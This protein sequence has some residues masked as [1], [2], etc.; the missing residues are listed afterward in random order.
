M[1]FAIGGLSLTLSHA[2]KRINPLKPKD[3]RVRDSVKS[4]ASE[5]MSQG[6][7][8][9]FE[10]DRCTFPE[11]V[12][13][14]DCTSQAASDYLLT[15]APAFSDT[16][17]NRGHAPNIQQ[18]H[19]EQRSK[20]DIL[21]FTME[22][23][24]LRQYQINQLRDAL[25]LKDGEI[26]KNSKII[27]GMLSSISKV[28]GVEFSNIAATSKSKQEG[29]CSNY[30]SSESSTSPDSILTPKLLVK[31]NSPEMW[32]IK[33]ELIMDKIEELKLKVGE[34]EQHQS[35]A[36]EMAK[37]DEH[38]SAH[39]EKN[40]SFSDF[41]QSFRVE[42]FQFFSEMK[43]K[44]SHLDEFCTFVSRWQ[45]DI[46]EM[47]KRQVSHYQ[48][49]IDSLVAE[50]ERAQEAHI[51]DIAN[52]DKNHSRRI[53]DL[54]GY[55][56]VQLA[57]KESEI[58]LV[59][60]DFEK[61]IEHLHQEIFRLEEDLQNTLVVAK[62]ME[63]DVNTVSRKYNAARERHSH[64]K[65]ALDRS[66]K[67]AVREK[68]RLLDR[69]GKL[70]SDHIQSQN[71]LQL[72]S[73][74]KIQALEVELQEHTL[75]LDSIREQSLW[76]ISAELSGELAGENT[77]L[78]E[79]ESSLSADIGT[80]TKVLR[81]SPDNEIANEIERFMNYICNVASDLQLLTLRELEQ[82]AASIRLQIPNIE[83][84]FSLFLSD[85]CLEGYL[86]KSGRLYSISEDFQLKHKMVQPKVSINVPTKELSQSLRYSSSMDKSSSPW[87]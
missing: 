6:D 65:E 38:E 9:S 62:E 68:D 66:L 28:V 37:I 13:E 47:K 67:V 33:Q 44:E 84:D 20:E 27:D 64:E 40:G 57:E 60:K 35:I 79:H 48:S 31:E 17:A 16:D 42:Q 70:E 77:E 59:S 36:E 50:K 49:E 25:V 22:Q 2:V 71:E 7:S 83:N 58:Q 21:A 72:A 15:P 87:E 10:T 82:M 43:E 4:D 74:K 39:L 30:S 23:S 81:Y 56:Q 12:D 61:Q 76:T 69:I 32:K 5:E 18:S 55:Y 26:E 86:E 80:V 8:L 63:H 52:L 24:V 41:L 78:L 53:V 73:A 14:N 1:L 34:G 45:Q 51:Q 19:S 85:L 75:F 29:S 3:N 11:K 46:Q 54:K